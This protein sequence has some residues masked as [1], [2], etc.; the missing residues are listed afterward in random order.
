MHR[1]RTRARESAD[2]GLSI[3]NGMTSTSILDQ[4]MAAHG[5]L[6]PDLVGVHQARAGELDW[7]RN[8]G[9]SERDFLNRVVCE[10]ATKGLRVVQIAGALQIHNIVALRRPYSDAKEN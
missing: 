7:Q 3:G 6:D 1:A 4:L 8:R 2:I 5:S 9:E 10:A